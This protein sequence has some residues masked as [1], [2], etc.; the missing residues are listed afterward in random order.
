MLA[1]DSV[2]GNTFTGML[3]RLTLRNP[4]HVALAAIRELYR[5]LGLRGLDGV[6]FVPGSQ[7]QPGA[8]DVEGVLPDPVP[9]DPSRLS[10]QVARHLQTTGD[11]TQMGDEN[12]R[13]P[14]L[15]L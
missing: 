7:I 1:A 4:F 2:A 11:V 3:T 10:V 13:N 8:A 12:E 9:E 14:A 15:F 5:F 6:S